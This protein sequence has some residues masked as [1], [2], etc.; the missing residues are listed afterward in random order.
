M[1]VAVVVLAGALILT[2]LLAATTV[3]RLV[4]II[5]KQDA[6][7]AA[8]L[9]EMCE[10]IQRP[11]L[12]PTTN[13]EISWAPIDDGTDEISLIGTVADPPEDDDAG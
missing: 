5:E 10:R 12:I 7:H 1:I 2:V 3:N 8:Q 4:A 9:R 6:A 13:G 11:E